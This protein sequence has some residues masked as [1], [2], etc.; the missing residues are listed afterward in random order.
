[1]LY[2]NKKL[3]CKN[4]EKAENMMKR[5]I[6][7]I[8]KRKMDESQVLFIPNCNMIHTLFMSMPIDIAMTD[9]SGIVIYTMENLK[10]W[11][12]AGCLKARDTYEFKSGAIKSK[13]IKKG[14]KIYMKEGRG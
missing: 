14:D 3:I 11:R 9:K 7:L 13:A 5:A 8:G 10:P 6:G 1:L 12:V 4:A 2:K